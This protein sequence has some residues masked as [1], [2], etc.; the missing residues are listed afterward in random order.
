MNAI[1]FIQKKKDDL[2]K[3]LRS[4][5]KD[6]GRK[7]YRYWLIES[8]TYMKQSDSESKVFAIERMKMESQ[9]PGCIIQ[10]PIGYTQYRIGYY[11]IGHVG[12]KA[13]KW[14]WGQYSPHIPLHDFWALIDQAVEDGTLK[15]KKP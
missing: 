15:K 3:N 7:G 10:R 5:T 1:E 9:D 14:T 12:N 6:I 2:A 4:K 8:A 11:I 13:G